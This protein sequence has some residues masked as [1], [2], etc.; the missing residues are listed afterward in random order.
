M[1]MEI[2]KINMITNTLEMDLLVV[3]IIYLHQQMDSF[4][5]LV[6]QKIYSNEKKLVYQY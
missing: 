1:A 6:L 2:K 4:Q 3:G 5:G